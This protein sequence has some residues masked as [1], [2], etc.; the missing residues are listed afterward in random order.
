MNSIDQLSLSCFPTTAESDVGP[1]IKRKP[2]PSQPPYPGDGQSTRVTIEN[3]DDANG[4]WRLYSNSPEATGGGQM[5]SI[6][7][8]PGLS[9]SV[10]LV[11]ERGGKLVQGVL[12]F[13]VVLE[14]SVQG[15]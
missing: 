2:R 15:F 13:M 10:E 1:C 14:D 8:Q 4:V 3:N 6:E 11:I 7:E 5:L 12:H 9:V